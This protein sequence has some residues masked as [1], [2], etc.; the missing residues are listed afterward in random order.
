MHASGGGPVVPE[1]DWVK[2]IIAGVAILFLLLLVFLGIVPNLPSQESKYIAAGIALAVAA[3]I[4]K[5]VAGAGAQ[6]AP[7]AS[8]GGEGE[9]DQHG[10]GP[11]VILVCI[12]AAVAVSVL[13]MENKQKVDDAAAAA[14]R[15]APVVLMP[16]P[17]PKP[18][19]HFVVEAPVG[20]EVR[21]PVDMGMTCDTDPVDYGTNNVVWVRWEGQERFKD[22]KG[23]PSGGTKK[24]PGSNYKYLQSAGSVSVK[25]EVDIYPA[26]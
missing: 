4:W 18:R 13:F 10:A 11:L 7:A 3:I 17:A 19:Q 14:K 22:W 2:K 1:T 9:G 5:V 16:A 24:A 12:I 6:H 26:Q 23:R 20:Q 25:V 21:I 15:P 8:G